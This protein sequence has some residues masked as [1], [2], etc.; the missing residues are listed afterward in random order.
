MEE[1]NYNEKQSPQIISTSQAVNLTSTIAS[2]STLAALFFCFADQRSR[3]VRRFSIQSVGLGVL[4]IAVCMAAWIL[5]L[6]LGWIPAVGVVLKGI[7]IA[8][9]ALCQIAALVLR[10]KMM[11]HAYR[12]EAY[13]LPYVGEF[14]RRFE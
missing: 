3:A 2:V 6:I 8:A 4:Q 1:Q 5:C 7:F 9:A 10:V 12:G 11:F 13:A 14:L